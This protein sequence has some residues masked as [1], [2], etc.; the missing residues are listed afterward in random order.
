MA[1]ESITQ[2]LGVEEMND[3]LQ[4]SLYHKTLEI[5]GKSQLCQDLRIVSVAFVMITWLVLRM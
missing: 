4:L 2:V 1:S 5:H 3:A